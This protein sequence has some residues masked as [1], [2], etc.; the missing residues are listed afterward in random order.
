MSCNIKKIMAIKRGA[1]DSPFPTFRYWLQ[2][3]DESVYTDETVVTSNMGGTGI[4]EYS[5]GDILVVGGDGSLQR[6]AVGPAGLVLT[7]DGTVP[8]WD[9]PS[10]HSPASIKVQ[11]ESNLDTNEFSD[12]EKNVLALQSGSNSGDETL[13]SISSK[14]PLKTVNSKSL[15]G[16]GNVDVYPPFSAFLTFPWQTQLADPLVHDWIVISELS[17]NFVEDGVYS[18]FLNLNV[19][20]TNDRETEF[21][22]ALFLDGVELAQSERRVCLTKK[23]EFDELI[24]VVSITNYTAGQVVDARWRAPL[25]N[26]EEIVFKTRFLLGVKLSS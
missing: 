18:L 9:V 7:S 2:N 17:T 24:T 15:E 23:K 6:L 3:P 26:S 1:V 22:L 14:R 16:S 19:G 10:G 13:V 12:Y 11:Y 20:K 21:D 8:V 4:S 25:G 5:V